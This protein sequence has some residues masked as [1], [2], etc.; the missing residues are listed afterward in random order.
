VLISPKQDRLLYVI[1]LHFC[2]TNNMV[3]YEALVNGVSIAAE[4]GVQRLYIHG[5][6][7][8]I[9]NQVMGELSCCDGFKLHLIL[10][11]DNEAAAALARFGWSHKPPPPG[12]FTQDLF[13]PSIRLEEDILKPMLKTSSDASDSIPTLGARRERTTRY[14]CQRQTQDPRPGLLNQARAPRGR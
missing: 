5:D 13:K 2:A 3:E 14:Q 10:W 8:L 6:S 7:K 4:L 11:Q 12:V 9:V 1:W